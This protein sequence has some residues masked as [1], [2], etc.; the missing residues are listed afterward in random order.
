MAGINIFIDSKSNNDVFFYG[1]STSGKTHDNSIV[2]LDVTD[3]DDLISKAILTSDSENYVL[4]AYGAL[5]STLNASGIYDAIESLIVNK[6]FDAFYLTVYANRCNMTDIY[7]YGNMEFMTTFS[8]HGT[9]CILF[10]PEG[11]KKMKQIVNLVSER[12]EGRGWDFFLNSN[13]QNLILTTS[14][15][16]LMY[17]DI[18][19]RKSNS[20]TIKGTFC[21]EEIEE[22][23][24]AQITTR[25]TGN[26]NI[27][28]F[29]LLVIFILFLG[30]MLI[31][32]NQN[33]APGE[34]FDGKLGNVPLGKFD[35]TGLLVN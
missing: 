31:N 13:G 34:I 4:C 30:I 24:P 18:T 28:W 33:G 22:K 6:K 5:K 11:V 8:P 9:E 19:N 17:V 16:P 35:P 3:S 32:I 2:K 21:R 14:F 15:P 12:N 25:Y 23:L 7:T 20:D 1:S 27:F 29:F 26:L 10:S